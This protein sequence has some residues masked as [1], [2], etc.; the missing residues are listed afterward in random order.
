MTINNP[1]DGATM[2]EE[3]RKEKHAFWKKHISSWQETGL[4]VKK[5]CQ[6]HSLPISQFKYYQYQF[7]PETKKTSHKKQSV[8]FI[9]VSADSSF[10]QGAPSTQPVML[11]VITPHGYR[12]EL[13][14]M[15]ILVD[16]L[17]RLGA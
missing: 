10:K 5:Y 13:E 9:Q 17:S 4:T 2:R 7:A 8:D 12:I 6:N 14:G 16:L 1:I 11:S 15:D 3:L